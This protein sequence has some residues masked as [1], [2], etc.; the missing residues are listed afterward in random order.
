MKKRR[1]VP[2]TPTC[3][4]WLSFAVRSLACQG[5]VCL[6]VSLSVCLSARPSL[7]SSPPVVVLPSV[8]LEFEAN[9]LFRERGFRRFVSC[10][11]LPRGH[12]PRCATRG[13]GGLGGR[14]QSRVSPGKQ[15]Q[16]RK[17]KEKG[18]APSLPLSAADG[19]A[20]RFASLQGIA[21]RGRYG[22]YLLGEPDLIV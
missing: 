12:G 17:E 11:K 13:I 18:L 1:E 20:F 5:L 3:L 15:L 6:S 14:R 9:T 19:E 16:R 22:A 4:S 8:L 21:R 10:R 2:L 7:H